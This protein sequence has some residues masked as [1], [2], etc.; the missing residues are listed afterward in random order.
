VAET[1]EV[2]EIESDS[3]VG[4]SIEQLLAVFRTKWLKRSGKESILILLALFWVAL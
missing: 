2:V 4:R 3:T 1:A